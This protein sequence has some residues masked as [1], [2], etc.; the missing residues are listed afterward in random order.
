MNDILNRIYLPDVIMRYNGNKMKDNRFICP[1]C[2]GVSRKKPHEKEYSLSIFPTNG[3]YPIYKC[4]R[5][6][7]IE[8]QRSGNALTLI[9]YFEGL[10]GAEYKDVIKRVR[11]LG[12]L[13]KSSYKNKYRINPSDR[14]ERIKTVREQ[15][16]KSLEHKDHIKIKNMLERRKIAEHVFTTLNGRIGYDPDTDS[17]VFPI[18]AP[19]GGVVAIEKIKAEE[20]DT[21]KHGNNKF[22]VG[23]IS[24]GFFYAGVPINEVFPKIILVEGI[25]DALSV[26]SVCPQH[27]VIAS[28][29]VGY[30]KVK[31]LLAKHLQRKL[32]VAF[33]N[34][35]HEAGLNAA[36]SLAKELDRVANC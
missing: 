23:Q 27:C 10:I 13:G 18:E 15:Y 11:E 7:C 22:N 29:G 36:N 14:M 6:S 26:A 4:H 32:V 33:D 8:G 34:D 30:K 17:V 24:K 28:I 5:A 2:M 19:S 21:F 35:E 31:K 9:R 25:M 12:Y 16:E 3:G 20:N 1:F